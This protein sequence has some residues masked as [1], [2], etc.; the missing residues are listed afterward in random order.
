M[1]ILDNLKKIWY[2]DC[3]LEFVVPILNW[4]EFNFL[5]FAADL[6]L[7]KYSHIQ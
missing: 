7:F 5:V 3:W 1:E 4:K 6:E 2:L